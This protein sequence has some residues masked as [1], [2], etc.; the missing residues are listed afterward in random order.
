MI[1]ILGHFLVMDCE[2]R[3]VRFAKQIIDDNEVAKI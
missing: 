2:V 1:F 3:G